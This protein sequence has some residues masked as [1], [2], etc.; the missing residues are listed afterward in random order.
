MEDGPH[1]AMAEAQSAFADH[2]GGANLNSPTPAYVTISPL[3]GYP[4]FIVETSPRNPLQV[5]RPTAPSDTLRSTRIALQNEVTEALLRLDEYKGTTAETLLNNL[6]WGGVAH[7]LANDPPLYIKFTFNGDTLWIPPEMVAVG[8][9]WL[10]KVAPSYRICSVTNDRA[11]DKR[12]P[13]IAIVYMEGDRDFNFQDWAQTADRQLKERGLLPALFPGNQLASR[14]ERRTEQLHHI[15]H[16]HRAVCFF[17][18]LMPGEKNNYGWAL[19]PASTLTMRELENF[20][21][22]TVRDGRSKR[23]P[24]PEVV[25]SGCCAGGGQDPPRDGWPGV[26]Y[27]KVFLDGG[28]RFYVG[29]WMDA[30]APPQGQEFLKQHVVGLAVNFFGRWVKEPDH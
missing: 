18:H 19:T 1:S 14:P 26:V 23:N 7:D 11:P 10:D 4:V 30:I 29:A 22:S 15:F 12:D 27:P 25:F 21:G 28:V 17:G 24:V 13:R 3:E 6:S 20:F 9:D 2:C 5:P 8:E 16:D